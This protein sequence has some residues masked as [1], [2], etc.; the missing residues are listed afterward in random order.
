MI[1]VFWIINQLLTYGW[2]RYFGIIELIKLELG[3]R[4]FE[5][6]LVMINLIDFILNFTVDWFEIYIQKTSGDDY[7]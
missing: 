6:F 4:K 2:R 7:F 5:F 3:W 1:F